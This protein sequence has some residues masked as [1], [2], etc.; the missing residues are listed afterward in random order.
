MLTSDSLAGTREMPGR[1]PCLGGGWGEGPGLYIVFGTLSMMDGRQDGECFYTVLQQTRRWHLVH[2]SSLDILDHFYFP[3]YFN[4]CPQNVFVACFAVVCKSKTL[5]VSGAE[6]IPA[7]GPPPPAIVTAVC[8]APVPHHPIIR[9][10][11]WP[12]LLTTIHLLKYLKYWNLCWLDPARARDNNAAL[13]CCVIGREIPHPA[14]AIL[15]L[16]WA[17]ACIQFPRFEKCET[18]ANQIW[19]GLKALNQHN[20]FS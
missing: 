15:Q 12:A 18:A 16:S 10:Q 8:P 11:C 2:L 4:A 3:I 5:L 20:H 14:A 7:E 1:Y 17:A 9:D 13:C 6:L 19:S